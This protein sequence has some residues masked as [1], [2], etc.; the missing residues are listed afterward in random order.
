MSSPQRQAARH[1]CWPSLPGI[2]QAPHDDALARGQRRNLAD[3]TQPRQRSAR[4]LP[5]RTRSIVA[6]QDRLCAGQELGRRDPPHVGH[7]VETR[8]QQ[9]ARC[10]G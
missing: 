6:S 8:R 7:G 1:N 2:E 10:S 3:F 5:P 4:R 9:S